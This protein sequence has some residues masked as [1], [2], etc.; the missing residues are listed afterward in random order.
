MDA[1][2]LTSELFDS[3]VKGTCVRVSLTSG[4]FSGKDIELVAGRR[5]HSKKHNT[6]TIPLDPPDGTKV[7]SAVRFRLYKRNASGSVS[8]ALGDTAAFVTAFE[9][10]SDDPP[11]LK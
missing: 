11:R 3:L 8:L 5:S 4:M 7:H 1:V 6:D 10:L 2:K 9:F